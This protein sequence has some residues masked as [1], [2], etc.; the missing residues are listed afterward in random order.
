MK[1]WWTLKRENRNLLSS[2]EQLK[3]VNDALW[4]SKDELEDEVLM[5]RGRTNEV[6]SL[7]RHVE[8][9]G[10]NQV[11]HEEI[12]NILVPRGKRRNT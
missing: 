11:G 1:M 9:L 8:G 4:K 2:M 3:R 5:L 7:L 10:S 12:R 6:L